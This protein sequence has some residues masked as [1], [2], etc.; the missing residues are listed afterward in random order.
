MLMIRRLRKSLYSPR[1]HPELTRL[2]SGEKRITN[3]GKEGTCQFSK[4]ELACIFVCDF[5]SLLRRHLQD[6]H[7]RHAK[8]V[9]LLQSICAGGNLFFL[10]HKHV[11]GRFLQPDA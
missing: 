10:P 5:R 2:Q 7:Q 9:Q 11:S 1:A 3:S 6:L 8:L 4:L